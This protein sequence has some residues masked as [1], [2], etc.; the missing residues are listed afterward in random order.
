MAA[1]TVLAYDGDSPATLAKRLGVSVKKLLKYNRRVS[2]PLDTFSEGDRIYL[3]A[4]KGKFKG[5]Q[6]YHIVKPG[7]QLIDISDQYG[8]KMDKLYKRNGMDPGAQPASG[9][10]IA[11]RGK[12]KYK[13][14]IAKPEPETPEQEVIEPPS[15]SIIDEPNRSVDDAVSDTNDKAPE[16]TYTVQS[17]DTL[18]GIARMH[19]LDVPTLKKINNLAGDVIHPGQV[20]KLE[21]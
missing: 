5:G 18:Y 1:K 15:E 4:K 7:E 20:L 10:R 6:E 3:Q 8:V 17:R 9:Q 14:R 16:V 21:E 2:S 19:G 12:N 13:V 11:L